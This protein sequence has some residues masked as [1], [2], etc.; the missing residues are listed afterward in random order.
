MTRAEYHKKWAEGKKN[1]A[2]RISP[3]LKSQI[4]EHIQKHNVL[5]SRFVM[6]AIQE[7]IK[8]DNA[9]PDTFYY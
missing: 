9:D 1:I 5:L 3:E 2:F 7:Q 6:R 4:D 8:R